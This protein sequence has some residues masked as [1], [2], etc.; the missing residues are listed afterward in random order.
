M[1]NSLSPSVE[2]PTPKVKRLINEKNKGKTQ[3]QKQSDSC[4]HLSNPGPPAPTRE[5]HPHRAPPSPRFSEVDG[6]I[7]HPPYDGLSGFFLLGAHIRLGGALA[8]TARA[9]SPSVGACLAFTFQTPPLICAGR[10]DARPRTVRS[11]PYESNG[12]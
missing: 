2:L 12:L 3:R 10:C 5:G 4:P 6:L 7:L 11:E 9:S 1:T 8:S